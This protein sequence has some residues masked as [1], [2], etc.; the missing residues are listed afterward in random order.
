M[1]KQDDH[2]KEI[3]DKMRNYAIACTAAGLILGTVIALLIF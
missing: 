2:F 1:A 3:S